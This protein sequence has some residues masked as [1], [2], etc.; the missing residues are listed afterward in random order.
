MSERRLHRNQSKAPKIRKESPD[1]ARER[2]IRTAS[3]IDLLTY[4]D[5]SP[6]IWVSFK[7]LAS[8]FGHGSGT[9]DA[10]FGATNT[11][12]EVPDSLSL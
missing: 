4:R 6:I 12:R 1:A 3:P 5:P 7:L 2:R 10:A 8:D 11:D 9:V